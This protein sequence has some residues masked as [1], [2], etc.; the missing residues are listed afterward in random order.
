MEHY[1]DERARKNSKKI[2]L[3]NVHTMS[4]VFI[5]FANVLIRVNID[6]L[7]LKQF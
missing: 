2:V 3:Y 4:Q 5:M 6:N 7:L 1:K